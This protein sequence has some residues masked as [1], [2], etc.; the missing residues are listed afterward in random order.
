MVVIPR[1]VVVVPGRPQKH[2][3]DYTRM[4]TIIATVQAV[5]PYKRAVMSESQHV[6]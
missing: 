1:K 2:A 6:H 3:V 4:C 5:L